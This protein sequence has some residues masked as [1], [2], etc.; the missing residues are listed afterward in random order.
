MGCRASTRFVRSFEGL[1]HL[2]LRIEPLRNRINYKRVS[3]L[4]CCDVALLALGDIAGRK[5]TGLAIRKD[6]PTNL[7]HTDLAKLWEVVGHHV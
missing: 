5:L 1:S 2:R 4:L 3:R 7:V 6:H